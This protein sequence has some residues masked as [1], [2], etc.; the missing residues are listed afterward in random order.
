ME[1]KGQTRQPGPVWHADAFPWHRFRILAPCR[2]H[3]ANCTF[4]QVT[5]TQYPLV[6][7]V[8]STT[9][10]GELPKNASVFWKQLLNRHLPPTCL[11]HVKFTTFGLGDSSY[12]K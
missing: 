2:L 1:S 11:R 4:L 12:S 7:I 9:G 3:F 8:I 5:L 10:Q 6:I